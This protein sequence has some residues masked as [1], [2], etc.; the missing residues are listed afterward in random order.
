M[1]KKQN[2]LYI[3]LSTLVLLMV[4]TSH[5][6]PYI[7]KVDS[8]PVVKKDT[9]YKEIKRK[10]TKYNEAPKNAVIDRVWKKTPG[11][12]GRKVN[13]EESYQKMK[14]HGAYDDTLLV[15]DEQAPEI[16]LDSLPAAPI[17]R[18]HPDKMMVALMINVSWG[19]E[20]IPNILE[21]LKKENV[22]A[23][24]FIEGK[25]A[26][27]H[28]DLVEMIHEQNHLIGNHAYDHPDMNQ[29]SD[30]EIK[31]QLVVTNDILEAIIDKSPRYF[32]PPSGSFND[33][34]VHHADQLNMETLLW[35]VDTIDWQDPSVSVMMKRV[36]DNIHPGATILMHP[37]ESVRDGLE[38]IISSLKESN[39]KIGTV[40]TLLDEKR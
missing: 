23:T 20:H 9:L 30:A 31:E 1:L 2:M 36:N 29:L 7:K 12:N 18:G 39:Y 37:T 4:M 24:F 3:S 27:K 17:Y 34:V 21:T 28:K 6:N 22:K 32:A 5:M 25:W 13:V 8:I 38:D 26:N 15:F 11:R 10:A 14:Q 19:E 33:T 16:T 40:E 35:T